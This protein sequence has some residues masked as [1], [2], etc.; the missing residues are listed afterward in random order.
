MHV[1]VRRFLQRINPVAQWNIHSPNYD[2][3]A[4]VRKAIFN[5]PK[6]KR[7][8]T[9]DAYGTS[10]AGYDGWYDFPGFG[11]LAFKPTDSETLTFR[12]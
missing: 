6:L 1:T 9:Y 11:C 10:T 3:K 7:F 2:L 8:V 12:W 4:E 5:H